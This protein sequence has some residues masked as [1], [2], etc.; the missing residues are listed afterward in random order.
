MVPA[1]GSGERLGLQTPK[2]L[3][4]IAGY[5]MFAWSVAAFLS[6]GAGENVTIA[7]PGECR[8]EFEAAVSRYFRGKDVSVAVGGATRQESVGIA[9]QR[10]SPECDVVLVHDAARPLLS[11]QL[12]GRVVDEFSKDADAVIPVLP[13]TETVKLIDP[14]S[15]RV[16]KTL[17]RASLVSAQTPQAVRREALIQ[18]HELARKLRFQTTDDVAL[19]EHFELGSVRWIPGDPDNIKIT[20]PRDLELAQEF[21]RASVDLAARMRG[22]HSTT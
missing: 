5:P 15:S 3:V 22:I 19:I 9:L 13:L 17:D 7:V 1:A 21:L 16:L 14:E 12:I 8:S 6:S 10:S 18:A 20:Y 2:A 4:P 11:V